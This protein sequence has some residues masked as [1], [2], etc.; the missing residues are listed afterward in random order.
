M[1]LINL[2]VIA[3]GW[4]RQIFSSW[5]RLTM[6]LTT[7]SFK[8]PKLSTMGEFKYDLILVAVTFLALSH[9]A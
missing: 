3:I 7:S 2:S 6:N 9:F 1:K 4:S 5:Y 8:V